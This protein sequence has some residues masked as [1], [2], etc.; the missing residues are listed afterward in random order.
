MIDHNENVL[1]E[2]FRLTEEN[3]TVDPVEEDP[4]DPEPATTTEEII[5]IIRPGGSKQE[6]PK[7]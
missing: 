7:K 5:E 3:A 4:Q 2:E 1:D 6:N